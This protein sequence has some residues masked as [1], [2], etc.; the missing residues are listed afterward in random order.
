MLTLKRSCRNATVSSWV[1]ITVY[2]STA[3][4]PLVVGVD[5]RAWHM[6]GRHSP[7]SCTTALD[8]VVLKHGEQKCRLSL[9]AALAR[10]EGKW[11]GSSNRMMLREIAWQTVG[12]GICVLRGPSWHVYLHAQSL[13]CWSGSSGDPSLSYP[14][15]CCTRPLPTAFRWSPAE[16]RARLSVTG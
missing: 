5:P 13:Q 12:E 10:L 16:C 4:Q 1:V 2:A 14:Q 3:I 15:C 6:L 11:P 8:G 7:L 9:R